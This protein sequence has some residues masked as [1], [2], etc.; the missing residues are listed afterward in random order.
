M[1]WL[2]ARWEVGISRIERSTISV[3]LR[4]KGPSPGQPILQNR[5][6]CDIIE[7]AERSLA[8]GCEGAL[9]GC[10]GQRSK[11]RNR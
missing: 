1:C 8:D 2:V 7:M 3:N 4:L 6:Q 10:S 11:Q 5:L 9:D